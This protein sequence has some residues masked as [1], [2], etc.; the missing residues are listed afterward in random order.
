M[1]LLSRI[2]ENNCGKLAKP[3]KANAESST[4]GGE[5]A[6]L[7][8]IHKGEK[9]KTKAKNK[10]KLRAHRDTAPLAGGTMVCVLFMFSNGHKNHKCHQV[11][12]ESS[13]DLQVGLAE[14]S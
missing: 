13:L 8:K 14:P 10:P 2:S 1:N 7:S 12:C 9:N 11:R 3:K 5:L 4:P 6:S